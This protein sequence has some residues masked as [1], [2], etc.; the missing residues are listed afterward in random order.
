MAPVRTLLWFIEADVSVFHKAE[1]ENSP[2]VF[3][4]KT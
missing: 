1:Q 2:G 4:L 3:A